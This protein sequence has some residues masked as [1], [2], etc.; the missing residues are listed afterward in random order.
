[1]VMYPTSCIL[2][3]YLREII[4]LLISRLRGRKEKTKM[5][6]TSQISD[7]N[8][9]IFLL[10]VVFLCSC[11]SC[12]FISVNLYFFVFPLGMLI[13]MNIKQRKNKN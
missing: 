5:I 2:I 13:L 3:T 9:S 7:M 1:M 11:S 10:F 6:Q 4:N 12:S 8:I